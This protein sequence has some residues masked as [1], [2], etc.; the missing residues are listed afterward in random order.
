MSS[1]ISSTKANVARKK[2]VAAAPET[3]KKAAKARPAAAPTGV[4]VT[5]RAQR[6]R[7][8]RLSQEAVV[9]KAMELLEKKLPDE[10]T[11]A[12]LAKELDTATVSL[13]KYFPNRD[14]VL[15]AVAERFYSLFEFAAPSRAQPWRKTALAWLWAVHGH[16][17]R[18]PLA[19]RMY[20]VEG[21]VSTAMMKMCAPVLRLMEEQGLT[22]EALAFANAWFVNHALGLIFNEATAGEFR[23]P[24]AL[25]HVVDLPEGDQETYLAL[26]PY[27]GTVKSAEILEF[28]FELM[29]EGLGKLLL[30]NK[31]GR[32]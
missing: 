2:A 29:I 30:K 32:K 31:A 28:G 8:A 21:Q 27:I 5:P 4:Q 16:M 3:A 12:V 18:H 24:M 13:Y 1:A 11:L 26:R 19:S 23:Q 20:G 6:G 22:G 25:R 17:Q 15:D 14:A 7:P 9:L 10:I